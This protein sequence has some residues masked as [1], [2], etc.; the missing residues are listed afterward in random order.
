MAE[1][2]QDLYYRLKVIPINVPPLSERRED[3]PLLAWAFVDEFAKTFNKDIQSIER[4][5]MESLQR[6]SWPGNVRELRNVIERAMIVGTGPKLRVQLPAAV[7]LS[8]STTGRK[9]EEVEREHVLS[10]LENT[11]WRIRGANGAARQTRARRPRLGRECPSWA[12]A[13][14]PTAK[15]FSVAFPIKD[16]SP[17]IVAVQGDPKLAQGAKALFLQHGSD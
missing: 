14:P 17:N 1:F 6:Y 3:I 8:V 9:L 11:G 12:Y 5:S 15:E 13:A 10:M 7:T 4:E 16:P 2:R